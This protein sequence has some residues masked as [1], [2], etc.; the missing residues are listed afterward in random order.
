M[1]TMKEIKKIQRAHVRCKELLAIRVVVLSAENVLPRA[2][3]G[4]WMRNQIHRWLDSME[5]LNAL[6]SLP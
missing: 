1:D 3:L 6:L 5:R 2:L 4:P